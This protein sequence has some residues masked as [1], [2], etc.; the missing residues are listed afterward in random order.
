M[1]ELNLLCVCVCV[2]VCVAFHGSFVRSR[3]GLFLR[4]GF[5]FQRKQIVSRSVKQFKEWSP[6]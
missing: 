1:E 2:C 4:V 6:L 3:Y 5:I